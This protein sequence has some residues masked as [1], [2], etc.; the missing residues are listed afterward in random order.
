[1]RTVVSINN[2]EDEQ[3]PSIDRSYPPHY[4]AVLSGFYDKPPSYE[5]SL[6]QLHEFE[7][8]SEDGAAI[9]APTSL[10]TASSTVQLFQPSHHTV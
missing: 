5:Q 6:Q 3:R 7:D 10:S 4:T 9:I 8:V 1:M 2:T